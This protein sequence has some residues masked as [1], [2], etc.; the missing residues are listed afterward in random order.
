MCHGLC[1]SSGGI[2]L[3]LIRWSEI[4]QVCFFDVNLCVL[5]HSSLLRQCF[6]G[7]ITLSSLV[8]HLNLKC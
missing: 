3:I 5:F 8:V 7:A 2:A 6:S 4:Q 1:K